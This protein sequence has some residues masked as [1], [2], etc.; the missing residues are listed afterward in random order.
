MAA[1]RKAGFYKRESKMTPYAFIDILIGYASS[2]KSKSLSQLAVEALSEHDIEISKNGIDK[3]FNTN[4]VDFLN[5]LFERLLKVKLCQQIE[6]GWLNTFNR[7]LIKDGTRFDLPE[8]YQ[9]HLA[10]CGGSGSKAGACLQFEYDLK[11]GSILDLNLTSANRP[12]VTDAKEVLDIV[13]KND[14]VLRDL[15]YYVF[16][17]LTNIISKEAFF[18][19][20]LGFTTIVYE[21]HNEEFQRLDFKVLY[22]Y[23]KGRKLVRLHKQVWIG[24]Q[25]MIPVRLVIELLPDDVYEHRMRKIKPKH[26]RK[27]LKTCAEYKLKSRFN[28]F[29]TNVPE[30]SLPAEIVPQLYRIRWQIELIFK[31]W[32]S[33]MGIHHTRK[34]KYI[35]WLCLLRFKLI[36]MLVNWNVILLQRNYLYRKGKLLSLNKCFKTLL[37]NAN[38][39]RSAIRQGKEGIGQYIRWV[40]R[41][42]SNNHWLERKN[43]SNGLEEIFYLSYC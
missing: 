16:S 15:G 40:G 41:I 5:L 6:A 22:D 8:E 38:R 35:R 39:L 14:L 20:R 24:A 2:E 33:V 36:L 43:T 29:I 25:E 10:G 27:K 11:G 42:L 12:D 34:M 3:R 26:R 23:M 32:K 4:T 1:A 31:I 17:S 28:L 18:I 19:S 21:K 7:V 37:D 30:E 13:T 9:E